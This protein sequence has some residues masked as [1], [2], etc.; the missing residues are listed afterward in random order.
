M[1]FTIECTPEEQIA[2]KRNLKSND[3][4]MTVTYKLP[5]DKPPDMTCGEYWI[6]M[7]KWEVVDGR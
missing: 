4:D 5:N 7:I 6:G 1:R 3:N 2:F